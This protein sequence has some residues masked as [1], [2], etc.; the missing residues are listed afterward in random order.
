MRYYTEADEAESL[1]AQAGAGVPAG[2]YPDLRPVG[3]VVAAL[4]EQIVRMEYALLA[5]RDYMLRLEQRIAALERQARRYV[6]DY[7]NSIG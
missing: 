2:T 6:D 3:D 7:G 1:A 4:R 5:D